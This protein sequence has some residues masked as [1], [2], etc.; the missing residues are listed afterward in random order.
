MIKD[1]LNGLKQKEKKEDEDR[2]KSIIKRKLTAD[3]DLNVTTEM[4]GVKDANE[5]IWKDAE[6]IKRKLEVQRAGP[7]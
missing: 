1:Y 2:V 6:V 5:N 3:M 4:H 7:R